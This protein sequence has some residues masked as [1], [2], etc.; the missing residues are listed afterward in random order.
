MR[1][2]HRQGMTIIELLVVVAILGAL[3]ALLLPAVQQARESARR[4]TCANNLKQLGVA[5]HNYLDA[6]RSFPTG[7]LYPAN[8][9]YLTLM[10]PQLEQR[11]LYDRC[12]F[13]AIQCFN[14]NRAQGGNG[15]PSINLPVVQC[16]SDRRQGQIC[17]YPPWGNYANGNSYGV[18]GT[19]SGLFNLQGSFDDDGMLYSNSRNGIP[20]DGASNT[21][22]VGERGM[23][24]DLIYGWWACGSGINLNGE[25]DNL[26]STALGLT[27]GGLT[28]SPPDP[29][30]TDQF[31]FWS[32]HPGGVQF[33]SVDGNVR[34][35]SYDIDF[36]IFQMLATRRGGEAVSEN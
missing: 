21:L 30:F 12:D 17:N 19:Q 25:G 34:V 2:R 33:L 1:S 20:L 6:F 14:C 15:P 27:L 31:H 18:M 23:A 9:S 13:K 22:I 36:Q 8:W 24:V 5:L 16:P 3:V 26:L 11:P 29:Q 32:W 28:L 7:N 10:L 35:L 4:T